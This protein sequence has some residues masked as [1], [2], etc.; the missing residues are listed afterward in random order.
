M[1]KGLL[2]LHIMFCL[3]ANGQER[4]F[5]TLNGGYY[6]YINKAELAVADSA[7]NTADS[8]YQIA[9][10]K[11]NHSSGQ[12]YFLASLNALRLNNYTCFKHY[13]KAA[14][15]RGVT[16]KQ[17][18]YSAKNLPFKVDKKL[19]AEIDFKQNRKH[20]LNSKNKKLSKQIQRMIRWDQA[21]RTIPGFFGLFSYAVDR[22]HFK[23]VK[24]MCYVYNGLPTYAKET[25]FEKNDLEGLGLLFR[26]FHQYEL[27]FIEPYVLNSIDSG[28]FNP[29]LYATALEYK[30]MINP[31]IVAI[32]QDSV[33]FNYRFKYGLFS[34]KYLGQE[35][36]Q[37]D[38]SVVDST[39]SSIGIEPITDQFKKNN[40]VIAD[41]YKYPADTT[42]VISK[43][44]LG[45]MWRKKW[46]L[47][48]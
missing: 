20:Y 15:Q 4:N 29:W 10:Q 25:V 36:S 1:K 48:H 30:I 17:L 16:K 41:Y 12:D 7:F 5:T 47:N 6:F 9:F 8:L 27:E 18:K 38:C 14:V 24:E 43:N 34:A 45:K 31:K 21:V 39:R 3:F 26:H 13:L 22:K 32:S 40:N 46:K 11:A 44:K 23:K 33:S 35:F 37:G 42:V 2:L 19:L 28:Y